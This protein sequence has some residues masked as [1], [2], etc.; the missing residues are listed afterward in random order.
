MDGCSPMIAVCET[1]KWHY[2]VKH[3]TC[4]KNQNNPSCIDFLLT[5]KAPRFWSTSV[6]EIGLSEFHK[7]IVVLMKMHFPKMKPTVSMYDK[8][9]TFNNDVINLGADPREV[10]GVASH[11]PFQM[12][13]K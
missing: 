2:L 12:K 6:I 5:N 10:H 8:Y 13:K 1:S 4:L 3:P 11:P 7:M 9:K